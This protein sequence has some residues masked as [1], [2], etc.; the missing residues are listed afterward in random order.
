MD[1]GVKGRVIMF[2]KSKS[3]ALLGK[4]QGARSLDIDKHNELIT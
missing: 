4:D 2:H 1:G 3:A